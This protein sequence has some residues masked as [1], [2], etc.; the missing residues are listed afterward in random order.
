V[1]DLL[2]EEERARFAAEAVPDVE[3]RARMLSARESV[4]R[5]TLDEVNKRRAFEQGVRCRPALLA[6]PG[7]EHVACAAQIKRTYFHFTPL[8]SSQ[9][10]HWRRYL[11]WEVRGR[12]SRG[13]RAGDRPPRAGETGRRRHHQVVRALH[14]SLRALPVRCGVS[15]VGTNPVPQCN[16]PEFWV[17]YALLLEQRYPA[18]PSYARSVFERAATVF[19]KRR[20]AHAG[21]RVVR[22]PALTRGAGRR[23]TLRTRHS[24]RRTERRT[25]RPPCTSACAP[26]WVRRGRSLPS[27][28][29]ANLNCGTA[30]GHVEAVLR[31]VALHRRRGAHA[32]ACA[33]YERA[34]ESADSVARAF[35]AAH[36]AR[37]QATVLGQPDRAREILR[38]A[39]SRA[40]DNKLLWYAAARLELD[41]GGT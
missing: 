2:T 8:E 32:A 33:V 6:A 29:R 30:V 39:L 19:L 13:L 14:H 10:D 40:A 37:F 17:R 5:A 9:L 31:Y 28:R 26:S 18:E 4:Y 11:E 12:C 41:V 7:A 23:C 24:R 21:L 20:Y 38:I 1:A 36:Y 15:A 25:A 22:A 16:Y 35:L 3:Q 34:M 27:T